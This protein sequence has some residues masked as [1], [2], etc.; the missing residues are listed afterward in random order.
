MCLWWAWKL[1]KREGGYV[2]FSFAP[3]F[4]VMVF[5]KSGIWH[6]T[7]KHYQGKWHEEKLDLE[8]LLQWFE[9]KGKNA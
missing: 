5:A 4:H 3:N 7:T 1:W 6:G 8:K 9:T 2:L